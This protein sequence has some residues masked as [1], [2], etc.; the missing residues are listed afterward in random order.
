MWVHD[1][2]HIYVEQA[3]CSRRL[4]GA[5]ARHHVYHAKFPRTDTA[6]DHLGAQDD[7]AQHVLREQ[8]HT[9]I[10]RAERV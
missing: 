4:R 6:D 3:L 9:F 7:T 1:T 10:L 2:A 8:D 5:T